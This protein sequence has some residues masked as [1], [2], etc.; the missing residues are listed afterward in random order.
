MAN[1][2]AVS[3]SDRIRLAIQVAGIADF[4]Q[5]GTDDVLWYNPATGEP[6]SGR[7]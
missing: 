4:D 5:D 1:G 6:K 2:P 7:S 3:I